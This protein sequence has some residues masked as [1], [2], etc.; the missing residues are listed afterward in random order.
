VSLP[1]KFATSLLKDVNGVIDLDV[2]VSGTLDDPTFRVGPIVWKVIKNLL[3]KI[4]TAPFRWLG[5]LF[6]GAEDAQFVDFAPGVATLEP[7]ARERLATLAKGL[8]QKPGN[9]ARTSRSG[10]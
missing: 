8:A 7:A 6:K 3:T 2:P 9:Q 1:I 4:V 10:P 5:G